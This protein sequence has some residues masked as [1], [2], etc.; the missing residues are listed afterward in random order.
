MKRFNLEAIPSSSHIDPE[1]YTTIRGQALVEFSLI[2]VLLLVVTWIPADFGL[3]LYT[4]QL[5][6]SASREGARIAAADP[7]LVSGSCTMPCSSAPAGT[8]LK[9]TADRM[10]AALL[11]SASITVTYPFAGAACNREV[12]VSV[13]GTYNFA[14]YQ[15]LRLLGQSVPNTT[16]I[17]RVTDMRWEHQEGCAP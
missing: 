10:S 13:A 6:Q 1:L 17:V 7:N 12:R 16:N 3:G 4:G 8:A 5:A 15:L 11:P 2:F 9:A 14:F